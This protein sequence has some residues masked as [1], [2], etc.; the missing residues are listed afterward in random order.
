MVEMNLHYEGELRCTA[1]HGPSGTRIATDAPVDNHGRGESFSPTDLVGAA[2]GSCMLTVM[3]IL[4]QKQGWDITGIDVRVQKDMTKALPRRI[5]RLT[6]DF[7]VPPTVAQA[8][9]ADEK[10]RLRHAALTCPVRLSIAE[11]IEVPVTFDW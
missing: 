6:V 4:A 9:D 7:R 3:G 1:R 5:E 11:S 10:Q 8:L 2:L